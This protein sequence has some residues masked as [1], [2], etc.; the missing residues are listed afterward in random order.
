[1]R[2]TKSQSLLPWWT[3]SCLVGGSHWDSSRQTSEQ[4][5]KY[6]RRGYTFYANA[7]RGDGNTQLTWPLKAALCISALSQQTVEAALC[8]A[9][10]G[11]EFN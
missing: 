3:F 9:L 7:S 11:V 8:G 6:L 1:M 2:R 10:C 4:L 5:Q